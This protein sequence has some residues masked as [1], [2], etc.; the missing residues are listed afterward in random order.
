MDEQVNTVTVGTAGRN[1]PGLVPLTTVEQQLAS[2]GS[3]PPPKQKK[4]PDEIIPGEYS[5]PVIGGL[6]EGAAGFLQGGGEKTGDAANKAI[7]SVPGGKAAIEAGKTVENVG[8]WTDELGRLLS[9]ESLKRFGLI[10]AGVLLL[11]FAALMLVH[12]MGGPTPIPIPV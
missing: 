3:I 11:L 12:A 1:L 7:E 10:V 6:L 4:K 2:H 5:V 9:A 8:S